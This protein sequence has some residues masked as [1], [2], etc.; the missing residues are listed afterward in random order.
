ME[1]TKVK[2][3]RKKRRKKKKKNRNNYIINDFHMNSS[4]LGYGSP[5]NK[6][7]NIGTNGYSKMDTKNLKLRYETSK[8]YIYRSKNRLRTICIVLAFVPFLALIFSI[9]SNMAGYRSN[10]VIPYCLFTIPLILLLFG[11]V[12]TI[13]SIYTTL[14]VFMIYGVVTFLYV[15][16]VLV[17]GILLCNSIA[18]QNPI[19]K[20]LYIIIV[21]ILYI[22]IIF[23]VY[24][25]ISEL[26][27]LS[28]VTK[29]YNKAH[30]TLLLKIERLNVLDNKIQGDTFDDRPYLNE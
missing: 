25:S 12:Y 9:N 19:S 13:E 28:R 7:K 16:F 2:K 27:N 17:H 5:I 11:Y 20:P 24:V 1:F 4:I 6:V 30:G 3:H 18:C 22:E 23:V 8:R 26:P 29:K 10:F 14:I 21:V 15:T